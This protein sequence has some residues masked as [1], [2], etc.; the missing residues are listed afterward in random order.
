MN[1]KSEML[2]SV[3]L[4]L[5]RVGIGVLMLVHGIGKIQGFAELSG[6]LPDPIG[7]GSR[8]SLIMAIGAEVGCSVLLILGA[9]TRLAAIPLA[10]TMIVAL[11]IVHA[12]DPWKVKELAAVFLLV[13]LSLVLTGPGRLSLDHWW[14]S[15]RGAIVSK[16][17]Q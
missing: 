11:F 12:A 10:F 1:S 3:G 5:L 7:L 6:T 15:K 2:S 13:Y 16:R 14:F 17:S 8:F 4:L 9:F